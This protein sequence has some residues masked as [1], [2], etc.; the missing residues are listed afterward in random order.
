MKKQISI[1]FSAIAMMFA[2]AACNGGVNPP[3]GD[4]N[5][6]GNG[7]GQD[8]VP[9]DS[10][11]NPPVGDVIKLE[12]KATEFEGDRYNKL[13]YCYNVIFTIPGSD[14][15]IN[16]FEQGGQGFIQYDLK[17]GTAYMIYVFSKKNRSEVPEPGKYT[18]GWYDS[19]DSENVAGEEYGRMGTFARG[20]NAAE[21]VPGTEGQHAPVGSFKMSKPETG[22]Y[23]DDDVYRYVRDGELEIIKNENGT[24]TW[25]MT[26]KFSDLTTEK[27]TYTG[28]YTVK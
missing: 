18:I 16:E 7:D 21:G 22:N 6:N 15:I 14:F 2:M 13:N 19:G 25:N 10:T 11:V 12:Y 26:L 8:T 24:Y 3:A 1:F 27:L 4:G 9:G 17:K 28:R 5:G 20:Y 23:T